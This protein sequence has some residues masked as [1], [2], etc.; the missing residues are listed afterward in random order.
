MLL[1]V[2]NE[3]VFVI[4]GTNERVEDFFRLVKKRGLMKDL[5][6]Q[7]IEDKECDIL[8]DLTDDQKKILNYA[9]KYGYYDYP[10]KITSEELSEKTGI[11][12]DVVLESLRKA[13]KQIIKR[14][15]EDSPI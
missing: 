14:I 5:K 15:L 11:N 12:K 6:I 1:T 9:K 7:R 4:K 2:C 10:R 8:D 13:E 3:N